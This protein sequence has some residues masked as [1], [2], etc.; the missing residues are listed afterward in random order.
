M[1]CLCPEVCSSNSAE[2]DEVDRVVRSL[3]ALGDCGYRRAGLLATT[4]V[5]K[6]NESD[7]ADDGVAVNEGVVSSREGSIK[8]VADAF[9]EAIA[10]HRHWE[11]EPGP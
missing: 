3:Q 9:I 7:D 11:R 4:L 5:G 8:D 1:Q 6:Y 10:L 2:Q